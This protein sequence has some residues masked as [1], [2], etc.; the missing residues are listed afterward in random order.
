MHNIMSKVELIPWDPSN[1]AH[2]RRMQDQRVSFGW[3]PPSPSKDKEWHLEA[4]KAVYWITL[5]DEFVGKEEALRKHTERHTAEREPIL[6]TAKTIALVER[7]PT[8]KSFI[9]IG[10][11]LLDRAPPPVADCVDSPETTIWLKSLYISWAL[12]GSGLGRQ[13]VFAIEEI[14]SRKPFNAASTAL[15]TITKEFQ[16][17]E[18][19]LRAYYDDLGNG[20]PKIVN[21][22]WYQRL[23]YRIVGK[24]HDEIPDE[25]TGGVKIIPLLIM[26]KQLMIVDKLVV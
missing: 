22:D 11:V 18:W 14:A 6:D 10:H 1:E 12:Q 5:S 15:D 8:S 4:R 25:K 20:R 19:Y 2:F 9:P 13:A 17:E 7:T 24:R 3:F 16:G 26:Q 23:G 21:E